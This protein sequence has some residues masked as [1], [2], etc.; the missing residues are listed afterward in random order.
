M[1]FM[2]VKPTQMGKGKPEGV[3]VCFIYADSP[4]EWLVK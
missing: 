1:G 2:E 3:S 4:S